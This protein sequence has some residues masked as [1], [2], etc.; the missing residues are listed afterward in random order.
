MINIFIGNVKTGRLRK[1]HPQRRIDTDS[2]AIKV[3]PMVIQPLGHRVDS[4]G[5]AV[6][7]ADIEVPLQTA[8]AE[9]IC[10]ASQL[11]EATANLRF[12]GHTVKN[13]AGTAP[14]KQQCIR[15]PQHFNLL[16]VIQRAVVL[17]VIPNAVDEKIGGRA[18]PPEHHCVP[19]SL[20]LGHAD[21][22]EVLNNVRHAGKPPSQN[23]LRCDNTQALWD[24]QNRRGRPQCVHFTGLQI[25]ASNNGLLK[26]WLFIILSVRWD[27]R[28]GDCRQGKGSKCALGAA[29]I[30]S[31][32]VFV[33]LMRIIIIIIIKKSNPG[34]S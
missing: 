33:S 7:Q 17:D 5:Y 20:T 1:Q 8:C 26:C 23:L 14:P 18:H 30:H 16:E 24:I 13:A 31:R 29:N 22:R 32:L 21:P 10:V 25:A 11:R 2:L 27:H 34:A 4:E 12:L 6:T 3:I 19:M 15:A 9:R 28:Q